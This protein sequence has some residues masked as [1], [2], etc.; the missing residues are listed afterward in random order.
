M[1]GKIVM[2]EL[3]MQSKSNL[4]WW[5]DS[6]MYNKSFDHQEVWESGGRKQTFIL[7]SA[8]IVKVA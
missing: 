8:C 1:C 5:H 2:L 4:S 6:C 3:E 7:T